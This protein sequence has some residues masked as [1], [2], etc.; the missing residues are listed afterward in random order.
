[1]PRHALWGACLGHAV[2]VRGESGD[3]LLPHHLRLVHA[4]L[5]LGENA[6]P[7]GP[8]LYTHLYTQEALT[9]CRVS[10]DRQCY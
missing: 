10:G 4:A 3:H 8:P 7:T 5:Q 1:M 6:L 2:S 9:P